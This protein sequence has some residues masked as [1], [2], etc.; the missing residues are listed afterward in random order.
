M[1]DIELLR[2]FKRIM[3]FF[4]R[5]ALGEN[6]PSKYLRF[7]CWLNLGWSFLMILCMI[8]F[9]LLSA[10]EIRFQTKG[11]LLQFIQEMNTLPFIIWACFHGV[12]I[13]S[14]VL[15]WRKKMVGLFLYCIGSIAPP[16]YLFFLNVPVS[17][18]YY[19]LSLSVICI[20]LFLV[21]VS[22]FKK[23]VSTE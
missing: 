20:A 16:I 6:S 4:K 14:I 5:I 1:N 19:M 7:L 11:I 22:E 15:I 21:K 9:V 3:Q 23:E 2:D 8:F 17:E 10:T 12:I 13:L 18:L